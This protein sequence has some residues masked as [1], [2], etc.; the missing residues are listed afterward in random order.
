MPICNESEVPC[1]GNPCPGVLSP[2]ALGYDSYYSASTNLEFEINMEA[3]SVALA[4]NMGL[5]KLN[6]L[7]QIPGDT[8]RISLLEKMVDAGHISREQANHTSSYYDSRNL[9]ASPVYC[10]SE[11]PPASDNYK[12]ESGK[13]FCLVRIGN[14]LSYPIT[15][16]FG[17]TTRD[18][19]KFHFFLNFIYLFEIY[20]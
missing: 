3:V 19:G 11:N 9:P 6:A 5:L 7:V 16:D 8:S 17:W 14:V 10:H 4:V 18:D 15:T 2:Q 13:V 1:K 20:I 12:W